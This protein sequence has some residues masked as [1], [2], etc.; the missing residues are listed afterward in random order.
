MADKPTRPGLFAVKAQDLPL[1]GQALLELMQAVLSRGRAFRFCARGWSMSP[2]IQDG[3]VITVSPLP[4]NLPRVGEVVAFVRPEDER[5]VVHRVLA[6]RNSAVFIQGD[7]GPGLPDGF[8]PRDALLGRVTRI[9]RR[10]KAVWLGLG[11]ERF[12]IAWLSRLALLIPLRDRLG[13][14]FTSIF[15][16]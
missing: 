6:R 4:S 14:L 1:S 10:G 13:T 7:N 3:D 12:A 16:R 11:P 9:E 15:R 5:L 8:I 2:F